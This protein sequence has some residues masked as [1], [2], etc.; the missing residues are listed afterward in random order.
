MPFFVI[1]SGY[2]YHE[3][4]W[5]KM[6]LSFWSII[7]PYLLTMLVY[8]TVVGVRS[9]WTFVYIIKRWA[10]TCILGLS[11]ENKLLFAEPLGYVTNSINVGVLWFIPY[12][13]LVRILFK[14]ICDIAG[15][16]EIFRIL[17]CMCLSVA[18]VLLSNYGY[19][20][21]FSADIGL[22]SIPFML[23]GYYMRKYS[24]LDKVRVLSLNFIVLALIWVLGICFSNLEIAVRIYSNTYISFIAAV[25]GAILLLC[26][27]REIE[28]RGGR[29][30]CLCWYGRN[31]ILILCIHHLEWWLVDYTQYSI[32]QSCFK[33][34]LTKIILITITVLCILALKRL[35]NWLRLGLK[36]IK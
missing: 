16:N 22:A 18:G 27:C 11:L 35:L 3:T 20:L 13:I 21:P 2:F 14:I 24:V 30:R 6:F 8:E 19:W 28:V 1:A 31:S 12:I 36:N 34:I 15:E 9:S 7:R 25:C 29:T 26:I 32:S 10:V 4:S 5:K 23:V 33:L 17:A